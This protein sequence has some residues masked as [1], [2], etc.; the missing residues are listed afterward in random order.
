[1]S[2]HVLFILLNELRKGDKMRASYL[3]FFPI[4]L[5]RYSNISRQR[6]MTNQ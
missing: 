1:M 4:L 5:E 2:A 3:F 6:M